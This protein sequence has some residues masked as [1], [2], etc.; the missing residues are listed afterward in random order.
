LLPPDW[1][2][3]SIAAVTLWFLAIAL[4]LPNQSHIVNLP[5]RARFDSAHSPAFCR[6]FLKCKGRSRTFN[7]YSTASLRTLSRGIPVSFCGPATCL[8]ADHFANQRHDS[9]FLPIVLP[10]L[11][12]KGKKM[13]VIQTPIRSAIRFKSGQPSFSK[14]SSALVSPTEV[15]NMLRE[16][17]FV[18]HATRRVAESVQASKAGAGSNA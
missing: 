1:T 3:G 13:S 12:P 2:S 8:G 7:L 17:A 9:C 16:I 5:R 14:R 6:L 4:S 15:R 18:L 11:S 10:I